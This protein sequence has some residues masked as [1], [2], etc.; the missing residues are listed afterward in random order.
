[1]NGL[2]E[3]LL[4]EKEYL[5]SILAKVKKENNLTLEGRLRISVDNGK[6]RYYHCKDNKY[7]E[8][9][10]KDNKELPQLLAQK[11]YCSSVIKA[12]EKRVKLITRCLE[13]YS[14]DEVERLFE[15]LHPE[16]KKLIIPVE[17]TYNQLKE[18]WYTESYFGKG[19]RE[20]TPVILTE[21]GE[22]VR[23]KSEKILADY[24]YRNDILYKYEKPLNL[25]GYGVVY[26][27]FTFF[28]KKYRKEL[29]WEHEGMMDKA[30]YVQNAIK[31]INNYQ[32]NGIYPGERLILTFET[33]QETLDSKVVKKLVDKYLR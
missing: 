21:K 33:S 28:S 30:D 25:A 31:K 12:T 17:P 9:I 13:G 22:R 11:A 14:D 15:K 32:K 16:R 27:D 26:P 3:M 10:Q 19:F 7:G 29:Y 23:S 1:M 2:K 18:R 4:K 8:Y 5:E 20:G 24:F 6:V